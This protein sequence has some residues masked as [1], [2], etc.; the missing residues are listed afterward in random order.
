MLIDFTANWCM[1]CKE[2]DRKTFSNPDV[3]SEAGRFVAV[4]VDASVDD[5][6]V[7]VAT[8]KELAVRGLPTVILIDSMGREANRFTDFVEPSPFL[9]ALREVQ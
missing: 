3:R 4:K 1:A 9:H 6:P 2:L 8:M 7:V 5:D